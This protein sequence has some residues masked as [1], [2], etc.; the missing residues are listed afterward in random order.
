MSNSAGEAITHP[1]WCDPD[2]CTVPAQLPA[3]WTA[4]AWGEHRSVLA[5]AQWGGAAYLT[6]PVAPWE[7]SVH[8]K[9]EHDESALTGTASFTLD[10]DNPLLLLIRQHAA[11][12]QARFASPMPP[13][14]VPQVPG[15]EST[16]PGDRAE[17]FA[18]D[19]S[20]ALQLISGA[21]NEL[22][23]HSYVLSPGTLTLADA[24]GTQDR[25]VARL[26]DEGEEWSTDTDITT[27]QTR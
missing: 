26:T 7:C 6:Q 18:M 15:P 3:E 1:V 23:R 10:L 13:V 11:V 14:D 17:A 27:R 20:A 22:A 16:G 12:Q 5:A 24:S 9:V 25:A 8:L 4:G 19:D 2:R 21:L